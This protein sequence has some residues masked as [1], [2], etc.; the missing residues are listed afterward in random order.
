MLE[1]DLEKK[2]VR[3]C[4]T[5]GIWCRKFSSPNARG[6]PDR[7]LAKNGKVMFLELKRLGNTPTKLQLRE[8]DT[9]NAHGVHASW[10]D[11]YQVAVERIDDFFAED[12]I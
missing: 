4:Q 7:I 3:H 6:V 5:Q 10:V 9:L 12:V 1:K 11:N 8:I 2:I